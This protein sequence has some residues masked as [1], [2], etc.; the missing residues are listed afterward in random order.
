MAS[1]RVTMNFRH[2]SDCGYNEDAKEFILSEAKEAGNAV[3]DLRNGIWNCMNLEKVPP[4]EQYKNY[5]DYINSMYKDWNSASPCFS[6]LDMGLVPIVWAP[7]FM[8]DTLYKEIGLL[9]ESWG[10]ELIFLQSSSLLR[11]GYVGG[12][13][14]VWVRKTDLAKV[15][16]VPLE[17]ACLSTLLKIA[18][19][20][21]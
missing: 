19:K 7:S 13:K 14:D 20:G 8:N 16:N 5:I 10:I 17:K 11:R 9:A 15:L 12:T 3:Y 21:A 4:L 1:E 18:C 6:Y 2:L